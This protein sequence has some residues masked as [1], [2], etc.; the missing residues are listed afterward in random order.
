MKNEINYLGNDFV[1]MICKDTLD[2][3]TIKVYF[4]QDVL[5]HLTTIDVEWKSW[6][7]RRENK[8]EKFIGA[9]I[10]NKDGKK[11]NIQLKRVIG[12]FLYSSEKRFTLLNSHHYDLRSSNI[13]P[14]AGSRFYKEDI[15]K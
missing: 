10:L 13:F 8:V 11:T 14:Y 1:E 15:Q 5:G 3:K 12:E 4:N 9:S 2:N 6:S 7:I